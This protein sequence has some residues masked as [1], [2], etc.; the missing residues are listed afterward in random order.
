MMK[1]K[2]KN[3]ITLILVQAMLLSNLALA[4]E[5]DCLAPAVQVNA[6][7]LANEFQIVYE[8]N[9]MPEELLRIKQILLKS[10]ISKKLVAALGVEELAQ[11]KEILQTNF[12]KNDQARRLVAVFPQ[13][14]MNVKEVRKA[15]I[16][17]LV[18]LHKKVFAE[19]TKIAEIE[20]FQQAQLPEVLMEKIIR[21]ITSDF[22]NL[23][24]GLD[25][26]YTEGRNVYIDVEK[27]LGRPIQVGRST[28]KIIKIK[29]VCFNAE[30]ELKPFKGLVPRRFIFGKKGEVFH[31]YMMPEKP[32]GA[33]GID[34]AN[35]EFN[36][37]RIGWENNAQVAV[38]I[39]KASYEGLEYEGEQLGALILGI[40]DE[41]ETDSRQALADMIGFGENDLQQDIFKFFVEPEKLKAN[42]EHVITFLRSMGSSY[43]KLHDTGIIHNMVSMGNV[44]GVAFGESRIGDLEFS[45]QLQY[46]TVPQEIAY[47]LSD[48]RNFATAIQNALNPQLI[49]DLSVKFKVNIVREF[50]VG[51]FGDDVDTKALRYITEPQL[52]DVLVG[53]HE[54]AKINQHM[55]HI[56]QNALLN[57]LLRVVNERRDSF[58]S[59][60]AEVNPEQRKAEQEKIEDLVPQLKDTCKAYGISWL[61]ENAHSYSWASGCLAISGAG[62]GTEWGECGTISSTVGSLLL[63]QGIQG[64]I[65]PINIGRLFHKRHQDIESHAERP[66]YFDKPLSHGVVVTD[67]GLV[68]DLTGL[69]SLVHGDDKD[70]SICVALEDHPLRNLIQQSIKSG[71]VAR[72]TAF[73]HQTEESGLLFPAKVSSESEASSYTLPA[74]FQDLGKGKFLT[75]EIGF[76][77]SE[78]ESGDG[79]S[80]VIFDYY[81]YYNVPAVNVRGVVYNIPQ[82]TNLRFCIPIEHLK[83][84]QQRIREVSVLIKSQPER[85]YELMNGLLSE[86]NVYQSV[87][88]I[89]NNPEG[90][91]GAEDRAKLIINTLFENTSLFFTFI[92]KFPGVEFYNPDTDSLLPQ[93]MY[94]LE[95]NSLFEQAI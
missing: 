60:F 77:L 39:G 12:S 63:E 52:H 83:N 94:P 51:Y 76:G 49:V 22:K 61:I 64:Y 53:I 17:K 32:T 2:I 46:A 85:E 70:D 41:K 36:L 95:N 66:E 1:Q 14:K 27:L 28:V 30:D 16:G 42:H 68:V 80:Q 75:T 4:G 90:L 91:H 13:G 7:I 5:V 23:V 45:E 73:N 71:R 58:D 72:F 82:S 92:T 78:N 54:K 50:L 47:R 33:M 65:V 56:E 11:V 24:K 86:D 62:M 26:D 15:F 79:I 93:T 35:N 34:A 37:T 40:E 3:I 10:G 88:A 19:P 31:Q 8:R 69:R 74:M 89:N 84:F 57:E 38:P 81:V 55:D 43:R 67:N 18:D 87:F 25:Y 9:S 21:I 6:S 48:I 44:L 29:G 20:I 59:M